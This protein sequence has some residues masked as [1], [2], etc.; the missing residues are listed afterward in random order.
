LPSFRS[1][2]KLFLLNK[3][4]WEE[5][6]DW[7]ISKTSCNSATD[8]SSCPSNRNMR[9]RVESD[10][11][12]STSVI[13][14]ISACKV[15]QAIPQRQSLEGIAQGFEV[16]MKRRNP[17]KRKDYLRSTQRDKPSITRDCSFPSISILTSSF[18]FLPRM[19]W[20]RGVK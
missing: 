11:N 2:T 18:T 10:N 9:N 5:I 4:R 8:N 7:P 15:P 20:A 16:R 3:P 12:W 1:I 19:L 6:R 13:F 17:K 14:T